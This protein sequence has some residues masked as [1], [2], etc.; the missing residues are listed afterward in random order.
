VQDIRESAEAIRQFAQRDRNDGMT[1]DAVRMR[2]VEIGEAVAGLRDVAPAA[3]V[4]EPSVPWADMIAMRNRVA[5]RYFD[6]AHAIVWGIVDNDVDYLLAALDRIEPTLPA[7]D[8]P[9]PGG[10]RSASPAAEPPSAAGHDL[11]I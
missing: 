11:G 1:F 8:G 9:A 4:A 6:T 2:L 10:R 7:A 5:H 3:L